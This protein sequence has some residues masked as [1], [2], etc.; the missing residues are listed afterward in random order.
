MNEWIEINKNNN[1]FIEKD[2]QYKI[3][4]MVES[5][6]PIKNVYNKKRLHSSLNCN[7][8]E[9]FEELA[10]TGQLSKHGIST[11]MQLP[12][13]PSNWRVAVQIVIKQ[14]I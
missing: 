11:V 7:S 13:N 9:E 12:G 1:V 6:Y 14:K 10:K 2:Y 4:N 5:Y 3:N 8:P